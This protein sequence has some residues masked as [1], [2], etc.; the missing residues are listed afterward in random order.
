MAV[1]NERA[2]LA[3]ALQ[4]IQNNTHRLL[5]QTSLTSLVLSRPPLAFSIRMPSLRHYEQ[6]VEFV[7]EVRKNLQIPINFGASTQALCEDEMPGE[8][9]AH[10]IFY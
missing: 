5:G 4:Y 7:A 10:F 6:S 3:R 8:K 1:E 9:Q 2:A